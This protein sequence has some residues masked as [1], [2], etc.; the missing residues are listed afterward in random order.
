M[1]NDTLLEVPTSDPYEEVFI[2]GFSQRD[3]TREEV[4][5]HIESLLENGRQRAVRRAQLEA[6]SQSSSPPH[7]GIARPPS[8]SFTTTTPKRICVSVTSSTLADD[9]TADHTDHDLDVE[10]LQLQCNDLEAERDRVKD[11]S[12]SLRAE[13]DRLKQENEDLRA[14]LYQYKVS[15]A[16]FRKETGRW[17]WAAANARTRIDSAMREFGVIMEAMS[18]PPIKSAM[19][20][21][22]IAMVAVSGVLKN[23]DTE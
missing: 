10:L 18:S 16:F 9:R 3:E 11:E 23:P 21:F 20:D 15:G 12:A 8:P 17:R 5:A 19:R 2:P 6:V 14:E 7:S 4:E 13:C 22:G 1:A